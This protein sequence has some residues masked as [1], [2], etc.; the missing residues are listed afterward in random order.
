MVMLIHLTAN[1]NIRLFSIL[2][3]LFFFVH[4]KTNLGLNQ[5]YYLF[6]T[7]CRNSSIKPSNPKRH[8][9]HITRKK[10]P[11]K[12]IF[13][14]SYFDV[15]FSFCFNFVGIKFIQREIKDDPRRL[16]TRNNLYMKM[17]QRSEIRKLLLLV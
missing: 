8:L 6:N 1:W 14:F 12:R 2:W 9:S 10:I 15:I 3:F 4:K 7:H 17:Y 16:I 11:A 13:C 5:H